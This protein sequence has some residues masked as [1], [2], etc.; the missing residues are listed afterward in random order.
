M[1]LRL[2]EGRIGSWTYSKDARYN[3]VL[4]VH[5]GVNQLT[6]TLEFR[7]QKHLGLGYLPTQC[8][9]VYSTSYFLRTVRPNLKPGKVTK[10]T[11]SRVRNTEMFT[12]YSPI[13]K[14]TLNIIFQTS[15]ADRASATWS[16]EV[17]ASYGK[18]RCAALHHWYFNPASSPLVRLSRRPRLYPKPPFVAFAFVHFSSPMT[19]ILIPS[20]TRVSAESR[21]VTTAESKI[22]GTKVQK[23]KPSV[24]AEAVE[25][26]CCANDMCV[27]YVSSKGDDYR[28]IGTPI[29]G[30]F[31]H[32]LLAHDL[33]SQQPGYKLSIPFR[34]YEKQK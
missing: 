25:Y 1:K 4:S 27:A 33:P 14:R 12:P 11:I 21:P 29:P 7:S 22:M 20:G 31:L 19:P 9:F 13:M 17:T 8:I 23:A 26:L 10:V 34:V 6:S 16:A 5:V 24:E 30:L 32:F 28:R 3:Y 2:R 18:L 15:L